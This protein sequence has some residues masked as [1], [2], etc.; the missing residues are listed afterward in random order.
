MATRENTYYDLQY[1]T[2]ETGSWVNSTISNTQ[3]A[4]GLFPKIVMDGDANLYVAYHELTGE[5]LM[6]SSRVNGV[7]QT[8]T[9]EDM[10]TW[11]VGKHS[12]MA[13]DSQGM[14]HIATHVQ[15]QVYLYSGKPGNFAAQP[16]VIA[17]TSYFPSVAVDSND[18][19]HVSYHDGSPKRIFYTTNLSGSWS[20]KPLTF[21][22]QA[23][24]ILSPK[25]VL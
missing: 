24:R 5:D 6:M 2:N 22:M 13:I 1:Y 16:S 25:T 9:I 21:R 14:I 3:L 10:A 15:T 20:S 12:D 8:E 19:V 7:W 17:S 11:S 4:D 23:H 18:F